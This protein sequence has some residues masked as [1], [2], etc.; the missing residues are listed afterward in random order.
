MIEIKI[1]STDVMEAIAAY[2]KKQYGLDTNLDVHSEDC[3][4]SE[5][6]VMVD[7]KKLDRVYK[8]HKNGRLVKGEYGHPVID[9]EKSKL[10]DKWIEFDGSCE[11]SFHLEEQE[12][13]ND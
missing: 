1:H 3:A 12:N 5:G 6:V 11:I 8:K 4:I 10:V 13:P 2:V 7:Y 9:H